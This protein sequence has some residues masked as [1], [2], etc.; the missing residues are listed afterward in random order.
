LVIPGVIL[1]VVLPTF[2]PIVQLI[3][4]VPATRSRPS[5]LASALVI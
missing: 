5:L 3:A 2:Q 4:A 1:L